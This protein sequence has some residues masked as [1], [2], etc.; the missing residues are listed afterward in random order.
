MSRVNARMARR[1][2]YYERVTLIVLVVFLIAA[3]ST[4]IVAFFWARNHFASRALNNNSGLSTGSPQGSNAVQNNKKNAPAP[5]GP[6][7]TSTDPTPAPW[8]GSSRIT[9]LLMGLDYRD[10]EEHD[11]PRT[12]TM[13]LFSV[14]PVSKTAGMIS[15]PRDTWVN[16]Q[17]AGYSKINS[18]YRWGELYQLPG[19]GPGTAMQTVEQLLGVPVHFYA[20]VDFMAFVRFIDLLG[21]LS[22]HIR[23]EITVDPIGPGNTRT[24][25][26]GVQ[27]LDGATVLA[28][29]RM[30]YTEGGDF[31]RSERQQQVI[32]ALRDQLLSLKQLPT[33][34][35]RAPGLYHE[36]SSGIRTNLNLDQIRRLALLAG[37]IQEHNIR[38]GIIGPP[39]Q[40]ELT[41]SYDGQ[42]VLIPVPEQIQ[43]LRDEVFSTQVKPAP[44]P[45]NTIRPVDTATPFAGDPIELMKEEKARIVVKNGTT[46]PGLA[47]KTGEM[48]KD[49]GINVIGED[50]ADQ[51]Y[52]HTTIYDYSGK[53]FTVQFLETLFDIPQIRIIRRYDPNAAQDI[54]IILGQDWAE[55]Q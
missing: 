11:I 18:A 31:D 14:D 24:I 54:E 37:Q 4:A 19:G 28:Y 35:D 30:R 53:T 43:I 15:I 44:L 51:E 26:P 42:A 9:I 49:E 25:E 36:L 34:I 22:M 23:E 32:L 27:T 7:Q 21:G 16:V 33:L 10:W 13:I 12:D 46:I 55:L 20:Q 39:L 29:A 38:R 6:L 41:T 48:L 3:S 8:D 1:R 40:V 47:S 52:A 50:N 5:T 2:S 17:G 45:T